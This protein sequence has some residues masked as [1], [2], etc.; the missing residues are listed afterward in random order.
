MKRYPFA[1]PQFAPP[2]EDTAKPLAEL[3]RQIQAG[4]AHGGEEILSVL[5]ELFRAADT[6]HLDYFLT[7]KSAS[8]LLAKE[9]LRALRPPQA[10]ADPFFA[11]IAPRTD[12]GE[13]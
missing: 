9:F 4:T 11:R 5:D 12:Q 10:I 7:E 2:R 6:N 13:V 1:K 3:R 8:R